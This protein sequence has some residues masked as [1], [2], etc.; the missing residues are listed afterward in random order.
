MY[1]IDCSFES[2]KIFLSSTLEQPIHGPWRLLIV[3]D[4]EEGFAG[5]IWMTCKIVLK[6]GFNA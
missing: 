2:G 5:P 1:K 4:M 3:E 6:P